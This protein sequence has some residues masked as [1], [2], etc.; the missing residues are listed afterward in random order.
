MGA[1]R[2]AD[3]PGRGERVRG[4]PRLWPTATYL[5]RCSMTQGTIGMKF[6]H[7]TARPK[8]HTGM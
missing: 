1:R 5:G 3:A 7:D 2:R 6:R 4:T 8:Q